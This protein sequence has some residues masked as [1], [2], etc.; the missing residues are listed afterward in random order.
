MMSPSMIGVPLEERPLSCPIPA[1][2]PVV[3]PPEPRYRGVV[4]TVIV[5]VLMPLVVVS[6]A[7]LGIFT[8]GSPAVLASAEAVSVPARPAAPA[9]VP[10]PQAALPGPLAPTALAAPAAPATMY[11]TAAERFVRPAPTTAG[12][13]PVATRH[14]GEAVRVVRT[15][16]GQD[17]YRSGSANWVVLADGRFMWADGLSAKP[18]APQPAPVAKLLAQTAAPT[19]A[20]PPQRATPAPKPAPKPVA[21]PTHYRGTTLSA[22]S[23]DG[24]WDYLA[25]C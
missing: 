17:P 16:V 24:M 14:H 3:L 9:A 5:F 4:A 23:P 12:N 6:A 18:L 15:V 7:A 25:S 2:P 21:A 19:R 11:V 22:N 20:P 1:S 10:A 8:P 13:Q